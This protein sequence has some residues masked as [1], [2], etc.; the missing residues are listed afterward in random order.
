MRE[1]VRFEDGR[2]ASDDLGRLPDPALQR[3]SRDRDRAD[4]QPE[5]ADAGSRRSLGRPDRSRDRQRSGA[6]ARQAHPRFA[7]DA[8]ADHGYAAG[9][10]TKTIREDAMTS[11]MGRFRRNCTPARR[12]LGAGDAGP[13]A[14]PAGRQADPPHRRPLG[15]R[16]HRRD[17]AA[18]RPE[19]EREHADHGAGREQGRRQL[20]SRRCAISPARRRTATRCSSSRPAR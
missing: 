7:A 4:R 11:F 5:R 8:G 19:D 17:G 15:R 13:C 12:R 10:I 20:H 2:V 18:D 14:G 16:R 6:R 1:Q 9:G 3:H